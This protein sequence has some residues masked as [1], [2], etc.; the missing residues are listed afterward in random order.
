MPFHIILECSTTLEQLHCH[1]E[2]KY[3]FNLIFNE[4]WSNVFATLSA[5]LPLFCG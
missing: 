1:T 2:T 4:V 3:A 5:V